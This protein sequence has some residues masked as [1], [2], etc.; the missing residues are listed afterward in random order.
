MY[1]T[2]GKVEI[3]V[4]NKYKKYLIWDMGWMYRHNKGKN[5]AKK[6]QSSSKELKKA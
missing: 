3:Q 4:P 2:Y 6:D 5:R 1:R